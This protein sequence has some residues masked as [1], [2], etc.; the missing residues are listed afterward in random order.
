MKMNYLVCWLNS[1]KLKLIIGDIMTTNFWII[2]AFIFVIALFLIEQ[3]LTEMKASAFFSDSDSIRSFRKQCAGEGVFI[4]IDSRHHTVLFNV[5]HKGITYEI[6]VP[7]HVA[8]SMYKSTRKGGIRKM[9]A[10]KAKAHK[11]GH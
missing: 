7:F 4:Y 5:F 8:L 1:K 3:M 6:D 2:G 11:G 9:V 10:E